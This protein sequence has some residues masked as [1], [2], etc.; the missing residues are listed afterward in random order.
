M[1]YTPIS[2]FLLEY[3]AEG[4]SSWVRNPVMPNKDHEP[5]H[6]AGK[7]YLSNLLSATRYEA[8]VAAKNDEG[9]NSHSPVYYFATL[10]AGESASLLAFF[11]VSH[12]E[13]LPLCPG[14]ACVS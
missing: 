2:E 13:S 9:W 11:F 7:Q 6:F 12:A 3:R 4:A 5:Y 10:G 14:C 1:S 8:R